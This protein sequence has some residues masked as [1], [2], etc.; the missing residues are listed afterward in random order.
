MFYAGDI[1]IVKCLPRLN[2]KIHGRL[3][4]I[5]SVRSKSSFAQCHLIIMIDGKEY[6]LFPEE[7]EK[8]SVGVRTD[9]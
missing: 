8:F 4:V 9:V 3:G 7:I 1:V 2:S 6:I 5:I